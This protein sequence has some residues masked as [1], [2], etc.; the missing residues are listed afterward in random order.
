MEIIEQEGLYIMKTGEKTKKILLD[1]ACEIFARNGYYKTTM[2]DITDAANT[3]VAAINYHFGDK[4]NLYFEAFKHAFKIE[5][6]FL[7]EASH[8]SL[9][10]QNL[11][12]KTCRINL[13]G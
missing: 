1:T 12:E 8:G 10:P 4:E 11:L 9:D 7:V 6:D 2:R 13:Q 5:E 3:N